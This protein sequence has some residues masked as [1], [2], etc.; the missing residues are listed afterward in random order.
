M[1]NTCEINLLMAE[2]AARV[3]LLGRIEA[4][5]RIGRPIDSSFYADMFVIVRGKNG[6]MQAIPMPEFDRC[7]LALW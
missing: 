3:K 1:V 6:E 2:F 5:R 4:E 7:L